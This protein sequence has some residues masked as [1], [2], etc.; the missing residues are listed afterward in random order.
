MSDANDRTGP[1]KADE[2]AKRV[3]ERIGARVRAGRAQR[4]MTRRML[5]RDSGVSERYIA[6]LE[7]GEGNPSI[8]VLL[9]IARAMTLDVVDLVAEDA[10]SLRLLRRLDDDAREQAR[11]L[12]AEK[13]AAPTGIDRR[14]RIALVGLRGAGKSTLGARL[15]ETLGVPFV[16]LARRIEEAAGA[17]IGELL[18]LS[19]QPALRRWERRCLEAVLDEHEAVV[20]ATG[21]GI[22]ATPETYDLLLARAH[23]VWLKAAP[24][25]HMNRV[26]EQGDLRPMA[27]NPEAMNDLR[28]ILSAREPDYAR[29]EATVDT[30]GRA[31][32]ETAATLLDT[33]RRLLAG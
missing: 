30:S 29:A 12:L 31:E 26:I 21:G 20:I 25:E 10:A 32:D 9:E 8:A 33:T 28:A 22:V 23:T 13:F 16:E 15:A 14:R 17:G 19:G 4:G 18:A 6:Q 27:R 5:A 7:A 1:R 24:E 3:L 2:G 11:A